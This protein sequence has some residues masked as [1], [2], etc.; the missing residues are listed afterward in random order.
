MRPGFPPRGQFSL[1]YLVKKSVVCV[2]YD[3]YMIILPNNSGR[4]LSRDAFIVLL[5]PSDAVGN[6]GVRNPRVI[7]LLALQVSV[8][9]VIGFP[10]ILKELE[11]MPTLLTS[12]SKKV[13]PQVPRLFYV[14][15][16]TLASVGCAE[17]IYNTTRWPGRW[18]CLA[19]LSGV[20]GI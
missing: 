20:I 5:N 17:A 2:N 13:R 18:R 10:D 6:L 9:P 11:L 7:C 19:G 8:L 12:R 1:T 14:S 15:L 4:S 16:I 3:R